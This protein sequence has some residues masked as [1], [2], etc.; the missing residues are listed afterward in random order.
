MALAFDRSFD[1]GD[2][3]TLRHLAEDLALALVPGDMAFLSGETELEKAVFSRALSEDNRIVDADFRADLMVRLATAPQGRRVTLQTASP[4]LAARL[5][6][7][8]AIRDFVA[9]NATAPVS[10]RRIAGDASV[11]RY[12][13]IGSGDGPRILMDAPEM[14]N[15]PPIADGLSYFDI[16]HITRS[17]HAF[18]AVDRALATQGHPAPAIYGRDLDNGLLLLEDFG[19][20][21]IQDNGRPVPGRYEAAI[22]LL[23]E[24]HLTPPPRELPVPGAADHR[25]CDY[26]PPALKAELAQLVDWYAEDRLGAPLS[27]EATEAYGAIWD[28]LI[29]TLLDGERG[30]VLR[31]FHSP[32][33]MWLDP[34]RGRHRIGLIDV[35]DAM[36]GPTAYDLASLI[37]DARVTVSAELEDSLLTRY[38]THRGAGFDAARCRLDVAIASAQRNCKIL[39]AFTRLARR[40]GR[41]GYLAHRDRV[42]AYLVRAMAHPGLA[43]LG[44]W[45]DTYLPLDCV[46]DRAVPPLATD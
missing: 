26:D 25:L 12:E 6:R 46:Q 37:H 9:A 20:E 13:R 2:E 21:T 11:R 38:L 1:I 14:P 34:A 29:A 7:S 22:D 15:G 36:I 41:P 32:N 30:W 23:A 28:G 19:S 42:A 17:V 3:T 43:D 18:V 44:E 16:A 8:F 31:D 33:L 39:G 40:D 35:Q 24:L 45:F 10:R 5:A 27:Q 4:D